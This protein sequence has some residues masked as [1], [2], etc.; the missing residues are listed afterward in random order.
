MEFREVIGATLNETGPYPIVYESYTTRNGTVIQFYVRGEANLSQHI[1]IYKDFA[2]AFTKEMLDIEN[3]DFSKKRFV[4]SRK[5]SASFQCASLYNDTAGK[6]SLLLEIE[7]V[8]RMDKAH[9]DCLIDDIHQ[10]I[11]NE[12]DDMRQDYVEDLI[13]QAYAEYN[14]K[15]KKQKPTEEKKEEVKEPADIL[16]LTEEQA[17]LYE[18]LLLSGE[19]EDTNMTMDE[20]LKI[21]EEHKH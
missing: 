7:L 12:Y 13:E 6:S 15:H 4:C 8:K 18:K 16:K 3:V 20:L 2:E 11:I 1:E 14:K 21:L 19:I 17:E 10:H 5:G 9:L